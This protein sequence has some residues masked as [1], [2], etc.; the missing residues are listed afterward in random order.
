MFKKYNRSKNFVTNVTR[1]LCK[2]ND[3]HGIVPLNNWVERWV[4]DAK[5]WL[6][7][8]L[9]GG[10]AFFIQVSAKPP[11]HCMRLSCCVRHLLLFLAMG[12]KVLAVSIHLTQPQKVCI[13]SSFSYSTLPLKGGMECWSK[14]Y[15][16]KSEKLLKSW[17]FPFLSHQKRMLT[18][19]IINLVLK[20]M[21][22]LQ[23]SKILTIS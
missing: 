6:T 1:A 14:H 19:C 9:D 4:K 21:P 10:G 13:C 2:K 11:T 16:T 20:S 18:Q 8:F 3:F 12:K 5:Y 22:S 15:W 7:S 17:T 23:L